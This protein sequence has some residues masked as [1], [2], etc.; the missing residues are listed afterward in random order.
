NDGL[1]NL[2][3]YREDIG[4]VAVVLLGPEVAAGVDIVELGRDAQPGTG[5]AHATLEHVANTEFVRDVLHKDRPALVDEG[6]VPRDHEEPAQLRQRGNDVLA[7]PV[8]EIFLLGIAA[9]VGERKN[10]DRRTLGQRG[11]RE[12]ALSERFCRRLDRTFRLGA[13]AADKT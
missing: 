1:G 2:I 13:Y 5:F 8:G 3:L 7:D 6:R 11:R 12:P 4:N 9:H 10:G